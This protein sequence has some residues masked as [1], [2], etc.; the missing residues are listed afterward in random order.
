MWWPLENLPKKENNLQPVIHKKTSYTIKKRLNSL[1]YCFHHNGF[2]CVCVWKFLFHWNTLA[3]EWSWSLPFRC[4]YT[5]AV[6]CGMV[7]FWSINFPLDW[8]TI[9]N[10]FNESFYGLES[11][12]FAHE[13][14]LTKIRLLSYTRR[15]FYVIRMKFNQFWLFNLL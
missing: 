8:K 5:N 11:G 2:V 9:G 12:A 3:Q 7:W 10:N 6:W 14:D 13:K 4:M 1:I 15:N